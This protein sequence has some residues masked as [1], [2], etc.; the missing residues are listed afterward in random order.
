MQDLRQYYECLPHQMTPSCRAIHRA[1]VDGRDV[2]VKFTT[3][4]NAGARRL[5]PD[6]GL[7]PGLIYD[8]TTGARY[9]G[10]I[11]IVM[12]CVKGRTLSKFLQSSPSKDRL[13]SI[14]TSVTSTITWLHTGLWWP[15]ILVD[16]DVKLTDYDFCGVHKEG[17]YPFIVGDMVEWANGVGPYAIMHKDHDLFMLKSLQAHIQ[18]NH[19]PGHS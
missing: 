3:Y 16:D 15:N 2:V 5:L 12:D 13:A 11:M 10:L 7:A 14:F 6:E 4:Y 1:K 18:T 9:G 17:R 8:G 19:H